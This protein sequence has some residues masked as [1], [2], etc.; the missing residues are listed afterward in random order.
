MNITT[1]LNEFSDKDLINMI[2]NYTEYSIL[3]ATLFI[4]DRS[5]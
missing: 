1:N 5:K 4:R 2:I 3:P